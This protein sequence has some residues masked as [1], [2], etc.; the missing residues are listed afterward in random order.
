MNINKVI[1][2]MQEFQSK[3]DYYN[4]KIKKINN[5]VEAINKDIVKLER[6]KYKEQNRYR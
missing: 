3:V 4:Q 1:D 6:K 5:T 2:N